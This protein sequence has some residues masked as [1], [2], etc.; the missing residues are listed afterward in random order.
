M[1]IK[2]ASASE[3][4]RRLSGGWTAEHPDAPRELLVRLRARWQADV[5]IEVPRP[6][7][8][9]AVLALNNLHFLGASSL[10]CLILG[11]G[12]NAEQEV[13]EFWHQYG[14]GGRLALVLAAT[15]TLRVRA[16]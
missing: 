2:Q 11:E 4:L 12:A 10:G 16:Q 14:G 3:L 8:Y 7:A 5:E 1:N 6:S 13:T 15:A 9:R